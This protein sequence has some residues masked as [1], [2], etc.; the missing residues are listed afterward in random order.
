MS[1]QRIKKKQITFPQDAQFGAIRC[2]DLHGCHLESA[3]AVLPMAME[4]V[5]EAGHSNLPSTVS[6][7][8]WICAKQEPKGFW[9]FQKNV[10]CNNAVVLLAMACSY[11]LI[12]PH[13]R[14]LDKAGMEETLTRSL[15]WN[16]RMLKRINLSKHDRV[17]LLTTLTMI[18]DAILRTQL[19]H[20]PRKARLAHSDIQKC[21]AVIPHGVSIWEY[22]HSAV[23]TFFSG[24]C[25]DDACILNSVREEFLKSFHLYAKKMRLQ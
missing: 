13:L 10:Y 24:E 18:Q 9:F 15:E 20:I 6:L 3:L 14:R 8:S 17:F 5:S 21:Y 1:W 2:S 7:I 4:T 22:M 19:F 25:V 11:A 12:C 23:S 16:M